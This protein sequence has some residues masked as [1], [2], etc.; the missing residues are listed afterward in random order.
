MID[1]YF[2]WIGYVMPDKFKVIVWEQ[3]TDVLLV[4]SEKVV[5]ADDFVALVDESVT[6]MAAEESGS[7][8]Y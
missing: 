3:V 7:S 6:K 8:C 2:E 4:A 5:Y 1:L